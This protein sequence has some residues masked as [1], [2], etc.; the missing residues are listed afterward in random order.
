MPDGRARP[1]GMTIAIIASVL[2]AC[3][4]LVTFASVAQ[5]RAIAAA[6]SK[7]RLALEAGPAPPLELTDRIA[8]RFGSAPHH[9]VVSAALRD[10]EREGEAESWID[11]GPL[12]PER[13]GYPRRI[14][15]LSG[16]KQ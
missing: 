11:P 15:R 16:A 2:L 4:G 7:V 1:Q 6:R 9:A 10:L 14:Y 5:S 13:R 8:E 3:I 12:P